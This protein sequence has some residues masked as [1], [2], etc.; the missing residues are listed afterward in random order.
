MSISR[1]Y[2]L[3][4]SLLSRYRTAL[5][6]LA[7][8]MIIACHA[9]ASGVLMPKLAHT[10]L[11]IGNFGVDVFLLLSGIGCWF[12]LNKDVPSKWG[13]QFYKK[14][15]YRVYIPYLFIYVPFNICLLCLGNCGIWDSLS[16]VLTLEYWLHHRGAWFVSLLVPLY[17][18]CPL[19]NKLLSGEKKWFMCLAIVLLLTIFSAIS[20]DASKDNVLY[21][22]KFAMSR[23]PSFIIGMS[24]GQ[25]CKEGKGISAYWIVALLILYVV[26]RTSFRSFNVAYLT[27][28]IITCLLIG[29]CRLCEKYSVYTFLTF[30]GTI[31]LESYL[32]NITLNKLCQAIIPSH[33]SSPIFYGRYLEYAVVIVFGIAVAYLVNKLLKNVTTLIIN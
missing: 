28:P 5:M 14:R 31:S 12:S 29:I 13:G 22:I 17:L 11:S 10:A 33:I 2:K 30:M 18:I 8:I 6:G 32:T 9:P 16:S 23:V 3:D 20:L 27:V 1:N 25:W 26:F 4:L 7:A 15:F 21:N 19:L 24:L